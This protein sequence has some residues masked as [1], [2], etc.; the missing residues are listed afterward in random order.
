MFRLQRG[1]DYRWFISRLIDLHELL[2]ELIENYRRTY[3]GIH[4]H[5]ASLPGVWVHADPTLVKEAIENLLANAISFG[6]EN[7]TIQVG[8]EPDGKHA[9]IKVC[10]DGPLLVGDIEVLFSPFI[11]SRSGPSSEHLGLGLYLVRLIAE[12]HGGTATLANLSDGSGIQA[13]IML[14]LATYGSSTQR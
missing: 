5:L 14:P 2:A 8:L 6:E 10:N 11:S 3:S 4:V 12:Q 13:S 7:S 1:G 9:I